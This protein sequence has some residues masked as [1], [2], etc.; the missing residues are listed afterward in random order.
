[1]P[2]LKHTHVNGVCG[3]WQAYATE[4]AKDELDHVLFLQTALADAAVAMPE[5][6]MCALLFTLLISE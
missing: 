6:N 3:G 4:I 5:I 2:I 1:M